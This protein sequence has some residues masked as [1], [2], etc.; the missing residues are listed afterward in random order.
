MPGAC[1]CVRIH[2]PAG[3]RIIIPA[4]QVVQPALGIVVISP[5]ADGVLVCHMVLV[6]DRIAVCIGHADN[7][8]PCVVDVPRRNIPL[9]VHQR[10]HVALQVLQE[11]IVR[12]VIAHARRRARRVVVEPDVAAVVFLLDQPPV[13]VII[14]V[15]RIRARRLFHPLA[16]H[17][18][19]IVYYTRSNT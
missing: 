15:D 4:V 18:I 3:Y 7:V 14:E 11:I 16:V 10:H 9:H 17:V 12:P 2:K 13:I 6:G 5:V 19:A 8:A 1:Q